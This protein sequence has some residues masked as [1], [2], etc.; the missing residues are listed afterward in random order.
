MEIINTIMLVFLKKIEAQ[1]IDVARDLM[2]VQGVNVNDVL[3]PT[4]V[5]VAPND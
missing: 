2:V 4:F 5:S 1:G 3:L